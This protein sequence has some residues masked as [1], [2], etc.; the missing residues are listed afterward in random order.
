VLEQV[1]LCISETQKERVEEGEVLASVGQVFKTQLHQHEICCLPSA[2]RLQV[3]ENRKSQ[4]HG[5]GAHC[6]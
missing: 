4:I 6:L 2:K 3:N 1:C 5:G